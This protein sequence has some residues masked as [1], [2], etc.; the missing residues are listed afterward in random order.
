MSDAQT[1]GEQIHRKA[2]HA[3]RDRASAPDYLK[4]CPRGSWNERME[5]ETALSMLMVIGGL[6]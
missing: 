5:I 3:Y 1:M 2:I 4:L 6:K